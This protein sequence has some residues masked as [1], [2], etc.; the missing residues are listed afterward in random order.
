M[1]KSITISVTVPVHNTARYLPACLDSLLAQTYPHIEIICVD[2]GSTDDSLQVLHDYAAKDSRIKVFHQESQGVSAARN[3]ALLHSTGDFVTSLDSD[4][5]LAPYTYEKAV[6]CITEEVDLVSYGIQL[7][8]EEGNSIPDSDGYFATRYEGTMKLTPEMT[9]NINV[10]ICTKLWRRSV[11]TEHH[12]RHPH[13]LV[14]EDDAIFYMFTP[15][16]R[17][18]AFIPDTCY[19]YVQ[20]RGSIMHS[21]RKT[22][23]DTDQ[24]LGIL[25]FVFDF[26][27]KSGLDPLHNDFIRRQFARSY[28]L[29]E[30]FCPAHLR[31]TLAARFLQY[32]VE[33]G[34]AAILHKKWYMKQMQLP[35]RFLSPF[36]RK[37]SRSTQYRLGPIPLF[38]LHFSM[39]NESPMLRF[40]LWHAVLNVLRRSNTP[41]TQIS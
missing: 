8:D 37:R 27:K 26:H 17:K 33:T 12:I 6:A 1:E 25:R 10:C 19:Y 36:L 30:R 29:V 38:S 13:G 15:F 28:Y 14:H 31:R 23:E 2:D 18:A 41:K 34:L 7:V 9:D 32:A 5:Y 16:V 35:A 4:D 11:M 24:Y 21:D 20:R 3:T 39:G 22:I 40:D